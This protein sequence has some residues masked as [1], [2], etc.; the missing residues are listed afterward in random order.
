VLRTWNSFSYKVG[1]TLEEIVYWGATGQMGFAGSSASEGRS[2]RA[3]RYTFHSSIFSC[4]RGVSGTRTQSH[5]ARRLFRLVRSSLRGWAAI[6]SFHFSVNS[7]R[8]GFGRVFV[9][10]HLKVS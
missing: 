5:S 6:Y 4:E 3:W 2:R 9:S 10:Y 7:S 1:C 8:V